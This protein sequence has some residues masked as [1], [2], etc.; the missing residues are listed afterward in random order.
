MPTFCPTWKRSF[1]S[2]GVL[3]CWSDIFPG[4][5]PILLGP[6]FLKLHSGLGIFTKDPAAASLLP[7]LGY[8]IQCLHMVPSLMHCPLE[9]MFHQGH[10]IFQPW[11]SPFLSPRHQRFHIGVST[12]S[13]SNEACEPLGN[14]SSKKNGKREAVHEKSTN[15]V[16]Y[17]F[18]NIK[19]LSKLTYQLEKIQESMLVLRVLGEGYQGVRVCITCVCV[20]ILSDIL[21][22]QSSEKAMCHGQIAGCSSQHLKHPGPPSPAHNVGFAHT[23]SLFLVRLRNKEKSST[24]VHHDAKLIFR[25]AVPLSNGHLDMAPSLC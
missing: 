23:A 11:T 22:V 16:L 15:F 17:S 25:G 8:I 3:A 6:S 20:W 13:V 2:T 4:P 19:L 14:A 21:T 1:S 24:A 12:I 7:C 18:V 5:M 9:W 10:P